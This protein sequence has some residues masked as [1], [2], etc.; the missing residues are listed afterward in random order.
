MERRPIISID[1]LLHFVEH[2]ETSRE[3]NGDP[4]APTIGLA[5]PFAQALASVGQG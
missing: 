5:Y 4:Q 3:I 1:P 2:S